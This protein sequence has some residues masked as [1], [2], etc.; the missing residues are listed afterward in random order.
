[1]PTEVIRIPAERHAQIREL[2]KRRDQTI[3]ECV[4]ELI[5]AELDRTGL[6]ETIGLP[7]FET[8]P[9]E[10]GNVHFAGPMG[11]FNWSKPTSR[12]VANSFEEFAKPANR[13]AAEFN[14]DA[15][16]KLHRVGTSVKIENTD[17]GAS[18]I[19]APLVAKE[20]ARLLR[21]TAA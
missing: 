18:V 14:V 9:L 12:S 16:I 15:D 5:S 2:A 20:I 4:G 19:V 21:K 3:A 10:N 17:T 1:M 11:V 7:P 6:I 8:V 13:E